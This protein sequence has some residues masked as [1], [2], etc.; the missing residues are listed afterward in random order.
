M[1]DNARAREVDTVVLGGGQAGLSAS[2]FL[3][4][5]K[6]PHVVLEQDR[7]GSTWQS[8]RWDSFTLVTPKSGSRPNG[9]RT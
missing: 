4:S 3:T 1:T 9:R 8:K 2:Y 5:E 6:R 7:I